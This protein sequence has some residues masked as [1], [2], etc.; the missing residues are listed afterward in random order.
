MALHTSQKKN[1]FDMSEDPA[2][3]PKSFKLAWIVGSSI[4]AFFLGIGS[5]LLATGWLVSPVKE[6]EFSALSKTV[7]EI[8]ATVTPMAPA[9]VRIETR[10]EGLERGMKTQASAPASPPPKP[11]TQAVKRMNFLGL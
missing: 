3:I 6:T 4:I 2:V 1:G 5:H 7:G 10:V 9:I 11:R 8:K